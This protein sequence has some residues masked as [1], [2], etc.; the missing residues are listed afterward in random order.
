MARATSRWGAWIALGLLL[1]ACRV[2]E[3][4]R[5]VCAD[6]CRSGLVCVAAGRVLQGDECSSAA[7]SEPGVCLPSEDAMEGDD[8]G[9]GFDVRMDLASKRDFDPGPLPDPETEGTTSGTTDA[10]SSG[11]TTEATGSSSSGGTTE[12]TGSS[13]SGGTTDATSSGGTTDASSSGS[14]GSSSSGST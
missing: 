12:A 2:G 11:G 8:D 5:C 10:T 4:D 3:G 7:G 6:D 1:P 14:G 13:S 9:G